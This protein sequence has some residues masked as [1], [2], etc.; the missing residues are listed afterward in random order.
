MIPT[1]VT[2]SVISEIK[3]FCCHFKFIRSDKHIK[4][5]YQP[6][7]KYE[8]LA[9]ITNIEKSIFWIKK[10]QAL[11]K[12]SGIESI[13]EGALLKTMPTVAE[14]ATNSKVTTYNTTTTGTKTK[15]AKTEIIDI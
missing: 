15:L 5:R 11:S 3:S 6:I 2:S 8:K 1:I 12:K 13:N 9:G 10:L 4:P 7:L 14:I